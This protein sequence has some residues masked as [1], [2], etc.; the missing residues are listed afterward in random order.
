MEVRISQLRHRN[1]KTW[2]KIVLFVDG[3]YSPRQIVT[4]RVGDANIGLTLVSTYQDG[5]LR[6][7]VSQT[8][9]VGGTT[10]TAVWLSRSE[11]L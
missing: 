2:S 9:G 3:H 5:S 6:A 8:T 11:T 7:R 1:E 4:F 10:M